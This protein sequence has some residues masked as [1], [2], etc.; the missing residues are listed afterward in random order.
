MIG[1]ALTWAH[2]EYAGLVESGLYQI[3]VTIPKLPD[4]DMPIGSA[5]C[6]PFISFNETP[7]FQQT[8]AGLLINIQ[9]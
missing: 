7:T 4:G 1:E 2:T 8:Q 9:N 5:L 6:G 3:N